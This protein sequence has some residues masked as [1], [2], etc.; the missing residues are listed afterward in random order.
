ML[1]LTTEDIFC[2]A[3]LIG[4]LLLAIFNKS[5]VL[6]VAGIVLIGLTQRELGRMDDGVRILPELDVGEAFQYPYQF[7][8][9]SKD[10]L[11]SDLQEV[12]S[13]SYGK[14]KGMINHIK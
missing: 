6:F 3:T 10:I 1:I 13:T 2:I 11:L 14:K 12:G 9:Q 8:N 4:C 7:F 5:Y